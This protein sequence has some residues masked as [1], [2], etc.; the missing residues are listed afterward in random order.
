LLAHELGINR[1]LVPRMP[2]VFCAFGGLVT[3]LVH[4]MVATVY[5]SEFDGPTLARRF[6]ELERGAEAWLAIQADKSDLVATRTEHWAEMRYLGQ[7]FSLNVLLPVEAVAQGDL[8]AIYGAYHAEYE[9]LYSRADRDAPIE[10]LELRVRIAG[11]LPTPAMGAIA[12]PSQGTGVSHASR[13]LRFDGT[14]YK[15]AP[16]HD[17]DTLRVGSRVQ[18]PAIIEQSDTTIFVIPG[19]VAETQASGD[20]LMT[21]AN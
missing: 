16:V 3:E 1:L 2:S 8:A 6:G 18:G 20:L 7:F 21:R 4:D 17:R 5:G 14:L 11:A 10:I 19:F 12:L 9:R 15:D 13:S